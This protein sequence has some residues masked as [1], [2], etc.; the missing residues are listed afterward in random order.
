VIDA[1]RMDKGL[2]DEIGRAVHGIHPDIEWRT[3]IGVD[4]T[5]AARRRR[6]NLRGCQIRQAQTAYWYVSFSQLRS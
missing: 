3:V 5:E 6:R 1:G 2:I 4:C